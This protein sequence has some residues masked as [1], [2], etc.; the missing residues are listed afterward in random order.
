MKTNK[1]QTLNK[2]KDYFTWNEYTQHYSK[3]PQMYSL[4]KIHKNGIPLKAIVSCWGSACHLLSRFHIGIINLLTGKSLSYVKNSAP[5]VETIKEA[6]IYK[7]WIVCLYIVSL[8]TKV[9]TDEVLL[10]VQNRLESYPSLEE[11]ARVPIDSLMKMTF[12]IQTIYF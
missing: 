5:F 9:P 11:H 8:F 7:N 1:S 10:V 2:K 4:P 6:S 3:L 12:W